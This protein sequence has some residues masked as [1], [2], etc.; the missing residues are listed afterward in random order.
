M[1]IYASHFTCYVLLF[2]ILLA[3]LFALPLLAGSIAHAANSMGQ[4]S[5]DETGK[6]TMKQIPISSPT[7]KAAGRTVIQEAG[8]TKLP[9]ARRKSTKKAKITPQAKAAAKP[10]LTPQAKAVPQATVAPTGKPDTV[11]FLSGYFLHLAVGESYTF[12]FST[13]SQK[14]AI[15][16]GEKSDNHTLPMIKKTIYY[17]ETADGTNRDITADKLTPVETADEKNS[18][19]D[20]TAQTVTAKKSGFLL[21]VFSL[22]SKPETRAVCTIRITDTE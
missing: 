17:M 3:M 9:L 14:D 19:L 15:H 6:K 7:P 13:T 4:I 22:D 5:I 12:G 2:I 11:L 18:F 16:Q 10:K 1:K 20:I 21:L 8:K